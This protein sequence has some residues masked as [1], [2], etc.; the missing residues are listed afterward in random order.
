MKQ[1][2]KICICISVFLK[3][4]LNYMSSH[5]HRELVNENVKIGVMFELKQIVQAITNEYIY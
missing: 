4:L 1:F 2:A 3:N 5:I